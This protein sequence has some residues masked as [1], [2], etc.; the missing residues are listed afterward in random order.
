[1]VDHCVFYNCHASTVYWDGPEGIGGKGCAMKYCIVDGGYIAGVWTCQTAEDFEF[2]HNIITGCRYFWMRRK[3]DKQRYRVRSCIV[4]N[5]RHYSG[6]GVDS[7]PT[8]QTVPEI[9][10]DE[11]VNKL[12][13]KLGIK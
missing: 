2:H 7:G 8:G 6:Y 10:F 1:V 5:N 4:T 12:A 3:G 13:G 11:T 9:T